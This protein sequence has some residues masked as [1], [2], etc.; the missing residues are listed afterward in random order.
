MPIRLITSKGFSNT[1]FSGDIEHLTRRGFSQKLIAPT[2]R[3][4]FQFPGVS[5]VFFERSR[6]YPIVEP[7]IAYQRRFEDEGLNTK[8]ISYGAQTGSIFFELD[9]ISR[10]NADEILAFFANPLLNYGK[11]PFFFTNEDLRIFEVFLWQNTLVSRET[12]T[13]RFNISMLLKNKG[14]LV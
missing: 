9:G 2:G 14:E 10:I 11:Q 7:V 1:Q 4:S 6:V 5:P 8:V 12:S 13:N 3:P